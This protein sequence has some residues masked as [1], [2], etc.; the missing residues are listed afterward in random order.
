MP[1]TALMLFDHESKVQIGPETT[2]SSYE[3]VPVDQFGSQVLAKLGWQGEGHGIGRNKDRP[4]QVIEYIPRQHRLGLGA[5]ALS[6][7]QLL[8][9]GESGALDKR[10][11]AVTKTYEAG[12]LGKNY[13]GI[14]E[15]LV[16]KNKEVL[17]VGSEVYIKGGTHKGLSGKVVAI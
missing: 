4:N 11:L 5:Q 14:D 16:E 15:E 6:K 1:T 3:R 13:K 17:S 12:T 7:E 8:K 2:S 9:Q 10:K